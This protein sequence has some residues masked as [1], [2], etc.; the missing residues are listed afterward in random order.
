MS[1]KEVN[2]KISLSSC[3]YKN[4]CDRILGEHPC[5]DESKD[6][7]KRPALVG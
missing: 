2:N 5:F 3:D 6:S 1:L 7:P 4:Y